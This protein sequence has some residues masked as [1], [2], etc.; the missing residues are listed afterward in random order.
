[1]Y[2]KIHYKLKKKKKDASTSLRD[3]QNV[4]CGPYLANY[5]FLYNLWAKNSFYII[6]WLE[7]IYQRKNRICDIKII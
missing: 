7:K 4:D 3:Q 2:D 6:K 1:M 5:L